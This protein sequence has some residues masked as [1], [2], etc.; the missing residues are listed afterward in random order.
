M[1]DW[2]TASEFFGKNLFYPTFIIK[3]VRFQVRTATFYMLS[4]GGEN[5]R[6]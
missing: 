1:N 6:K 2:V 4:I 3:Y 5:A